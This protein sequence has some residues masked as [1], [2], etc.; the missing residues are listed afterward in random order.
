M[1][2]NIQRETAKIIRFPVERR[3][4]AAIEQATVR[5]I[6]ERPSAVYVDCSSGW[7]HDEAIKDGGMVRHR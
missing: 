4:A 1:S 6:E 5:K 7:Y 3:Q 2:E